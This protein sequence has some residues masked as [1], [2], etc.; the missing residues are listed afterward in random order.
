MSRFIAADRDGACGQGLRVPARL[1]DV[2][3][4]RRLD[5]AG[6]E[7]AAPEIDDERDVLL[8]L[9][10]EGMTHAVA[11]VL[12][13]RERLRHEVDLIK[14]TGEDPAQA[15][16]VVMQPAVVRHGRACEGQ[17]LRHD[18][19]RR[20][21]R[22]ILSDFVECYANDQVGEVFRNPEDGSSR[23]GSPRT[24]GEL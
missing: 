9:G 8:F 20:L 3:S 19:L 5:D 13:D 7:S 16:T 23:R 10:N 11:V 24:L 22:P 4:L 18:Y 2:A 15:L 14:L 1:A 12:E 21:R 17:R 6:I